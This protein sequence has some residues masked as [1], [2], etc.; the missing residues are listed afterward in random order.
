M[1]APSAD[2]EEQGAEH[3]LGTLLAN[4]MQSRRATASKEMKVRVLFQIPGTSWHHAT[5]LFKP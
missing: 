1:P 5:R 2:A 4:W 3:D